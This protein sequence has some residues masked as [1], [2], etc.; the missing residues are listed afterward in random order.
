MQRAKR[1]APKRKRRM[2]ITGARLEVQ[3][4]RCSMFDIEDSLHDA[5][6]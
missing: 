5:M 1:K 2:K 6:C 4:L 3:K